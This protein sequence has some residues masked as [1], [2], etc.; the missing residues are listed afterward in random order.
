MTRIVLNDDG[1]LRRWGRAR[2]RARA[3]RR[4]RGGVERSVS[5]F[6]VSDGSDRADCST[7]TVRVVKVRERRRERFGAG[8]G[9]I[10]RWWKPYAAAGEGAIATGDA[11]RRRGAVR[12]SGELTSEYFCIVARRLTSEKY[13]QRRRRAVQGSRREG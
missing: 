7:R 5:L 9:S 11:A 8:D 4:R 1:A 10:A 6:G 13:V 2:A 12:A 3:R